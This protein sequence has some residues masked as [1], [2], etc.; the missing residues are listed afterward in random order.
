MV[1]T[2]S[3]NLRPT[4]LMPNISWYEGEGCPRVAHIPNAQEKSELVPQIRVKK[5]LKAGSEPP[6][7]SGKGEKTTA[8]PQKAVPGVSQSSAHSSGETRA[9]NPVL[10]LKLDWARNPKKPTLKLRTK[11]YL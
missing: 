4:M 8:K 2:L 9:P 7:Q 6:K 10:T 5:L 1:I 11:L 3:P